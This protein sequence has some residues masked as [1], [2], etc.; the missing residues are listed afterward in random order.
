MC[1]R[2]ISSACSLPPRLASLISRRSSWRDI[3]GYFRITPRYA[4]HIPRH[5]RYSGSKNPL[6]NVALYGKD[7]IRL[8][9]KRAML[10]HVFT[11]RSIFANYHLNPRPR[12]LDIHVPKSSSPL[13]MISAV[14]RRSSASRIAISSASR[15]SSYFPFG[16]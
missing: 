16:K 3:F 5:C 15:P 8:G 4:F 1:R 11:H 9:Q 12:K 6:A 10:R 7:D 2:T 13:P 14:I